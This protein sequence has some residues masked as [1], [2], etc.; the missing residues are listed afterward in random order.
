MKHHADFFDPAL[1]QASKDK[2][3]QGE[4]PDF[5]TTPRCAFACYPRFGATDQ[6]DG[7]GDAARRL[8]PAT[9]HRLRPDFRQRNPHR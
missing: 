3:I 4:L 6:N 7:A 2:L 5:Y 9:P 1:W 8:T